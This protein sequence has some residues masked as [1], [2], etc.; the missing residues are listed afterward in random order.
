MRKCELI[1]IGTSPNTVRCKEYRLTIGKPCAK[2]A[3]SAAP[4]KEPEPIA[5]LNVWYTA[6][7]SK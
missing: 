6:A 1:E 7:S 5:G 2:R 3:V 4:K